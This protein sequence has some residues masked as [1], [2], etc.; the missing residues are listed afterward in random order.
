MHKGVTGSMGFWRK[1]IQ[2]KPIKKVKKRDTLTRGDE[3]FPKRVV[4][5]KANFPILETIY[6]YLLLFRHSIFHSPIRNYENIFL[7]TKNIYVLQRHS[8][9]T[10]EQF[11]V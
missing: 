1:D 5:Q 4:A 9:K 3:N 6:P 8:T 10:T 11:I 7:H 2:N